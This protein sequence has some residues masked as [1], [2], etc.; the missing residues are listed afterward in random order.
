MKCYL[1]YLAPFLEKQ[2][3]SISYN[4]KI[5]QPCKPKKMQYLQCFQLLK[6]LESFYHS[7][8]KIVKCYLGDLAPFF[9][10]KRVFLYLL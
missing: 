2:F 7:M 3:F 10:R 5:M 8:S 9:F 6:A 1:D 4:F